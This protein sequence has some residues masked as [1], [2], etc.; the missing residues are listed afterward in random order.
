EHH[1][2]SRP[3]GSQRETGKAGP[4][5]Q[6]EPRRR[7]GRNVIDQ[8]QAIGEV[9]PPDRLKAAVRDEVLPRVFFSQQRREPLEA[10]DPVR[11]GTFDAEPA[12]VGLVHV[13]ATRRLAWTSSAASA[14]GVIPR[15]RP[16]AARV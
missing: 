6:I 7:A 1:D 16:A 10:R 9:T 12:R 13:H 11:I 2:G 14:A 3:Y 15:T 8:L 4:A 5:A